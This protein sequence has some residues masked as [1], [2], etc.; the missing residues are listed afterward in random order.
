M[1]F[2]AADTESER[3]YIFADES[4]L[5]EWVT[6]IARCKCGKKMN[7]KEECAVGM[8]KTYV[9]RCGQCNIEQQMCTSQGGVKKSCRYDLHRRL[10]RGALHS[11]GYTAIRELCATLNMHP[12]SEKSYHQ[13]AKEIQEKGIEEMERAMEK[14]RAKLHDILKERG[15]EN[16]VKEIS[17]SCDGSW[18]KRGFTSMYGFVSVIELT[19]GICVDFVL[20]SKYCKVCDNLGAGQQAPQHDCTKNYDG[21]S[22]AMEMEGWRRLWERS[23]EKCKLKYVKVVSD[24]DSKGIAAVKRLAIYDVEKQECI[25]HVS[26]RLGT[27]LLQAKKVGKLGGRKK[28]AL[29]QDKVMRLA[30]YFGKAIKQ[31]TTV[32]DMKKDIFATL[33]HCQSTDAKPQ[34]STCPDGKYSWCFYKRSVAR[35]VPIPSHDK[36]MKTFLTEK[37]VAKIL[38]IYMKVATNELLEKCKGD[39]QNANECLH[40]SLWSELPKTKF[41]SLQRM[42]YSLYRSV[43][44]FNHGSTTMAMAEGETGKEI[45]EIRKRMDRKR[46]ASSVMKIQKKEEERKHKIRKV[47][48]EEEKLQ[49]EGVTY[50]PGT[51]PVI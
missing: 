48:K 37:V 6:S 36:K 21:S 42:R 43:V 28:G 16:E 47:Q 20:L 2:Q 5:L 45:L 26:K 10:V 3:K 46:I 31:D 50:G 18:S 25:N 35:N 24:G 19:T 49:T 30:H 41:F 13:I 38:P 22:P 27:A 9:A 44:R 14:S 40:S 39:T 51:A 17:V 4:N 23:I 32:E 15:D 1:D 29:T 8:A 11:G 34:H 7:I 33:R 12:L